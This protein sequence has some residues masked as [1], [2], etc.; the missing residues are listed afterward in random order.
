MRTVKSWR[1]LARLVVVCAVVW[2]SLVSAAIAQSSTRRSTCGKLADVN[3]KQNWSDRE[4]VKFWFNSQ[5]SRIMPYS[6]FIALEQA[7]NED[8]FIDACYMESLGFI[9][10]PGQGLPIGFAQDTNRTKTATFI[11]LTCAACHTA[12]LT[13]GTR[14]AIVEGGPSLVDF[15]AFLSALVDS[16]R[17]NHDNEDKFTRWANR[18]NDTSIPR[19]TLRHR[20]KALSQELAARSKQNTP[21]NPYGFGRVDAFGHIFNRVLATAIDADGNAR[22]PNAPCLLSVSVG[23]AKGHARASPVEL[24]GKERVLVPRS[25]R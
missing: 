20:L 12:R 9:V 25:P 19:P 1:D 18:V 22:T 3:L 6:W 23:Y 15:S 16:T 10:V 14:T 24:V 11:G 21:T 7:T 8:L 13:I 2:A 17:A 4:K 5:G